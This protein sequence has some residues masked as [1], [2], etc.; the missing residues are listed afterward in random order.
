[1]QAMPPS[2]QQ[3]TEND[4]GVNNSGSSTFCFPLITEGTGIMPTNR[5]SR[6]NIL[7]RLSEALL[8]QSLTKVREKCSAGYAHQ[9]KHRFHVL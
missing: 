2:R 3:H 1:M 5:P 4:V 7:R 6:E 8:R 9:G